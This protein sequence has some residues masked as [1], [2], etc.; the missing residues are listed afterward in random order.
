M[1][2]RKYRFY[3]YDWAFNP[4]RPHLSFATFDD[5]WDY[6]LGELTDDLN[7]EEDDYQEYQVIEWEC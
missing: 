1:K 2:E 3:I 6:I 4:I 5:G 7:L